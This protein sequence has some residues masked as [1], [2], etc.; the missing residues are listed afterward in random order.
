M[1][2]DGVREV[3]EIANLRT[4]ATA[5]SPESSPPEKIAKFTGLQGDSKR[6]EAGCKSHTVV[7]RSEQWLR[8]TTGSIPPSRN[9]RLRAVRFVPRSPSGL[10]VVE[11]L[12]R[13]FVKR[14]KNL[15]IFERLFDDLRFT[16]GG[17][18]AATGAE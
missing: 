6:I 14:R 9:H 4:A 10:V 13:E 16:A 2:G 11:V 7:F 18:T 17:K 3:K 8:T 5:R 1:F 12:A 15:E